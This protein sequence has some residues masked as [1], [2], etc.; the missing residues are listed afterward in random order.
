MLR[1][2][3]YSAR[4]SRFGPTTADV[5]TAAGDD[6]PL[7]GNLKRK[8]LQSAVVRLDHVGEAGAEPVVVRADQRVDAQQVDV[9]VDDHQVALGVERVHA[10][11]GVGDDQ[12]RAA[13]FLQHPDREGDLRGGISLVEV[14]PTFHR[15][16][17][18]AGQG[19]ADE[20]AGVALDRGGGESGESRGRGSSPRRRSRRRG[21][22]GPS[23]ARCRPPPVR[24]S[25]NARL[26]WHPE[27][28]PSRDVS[29]VRIREAMSKEGNRD[30]G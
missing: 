12:R 13:Q 24:P 16:D 30:D 18:S 26:S 1:R 27:H 7:A 28:R 6:L 22:P 19:A 10:A 3:R 8:F 9:V 29:S 11:A 25:G 23:R 5:D 4:V 21:L 2:N 15:H 14:E 17:R 20:L